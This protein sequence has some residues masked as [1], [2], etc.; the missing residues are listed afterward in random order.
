ML[1]GIPFTSL[2]REVSLR[3]RNELEVANCIIAATLILVA[4]TSG[5]VDPQTNRT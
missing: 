1:S 4:T 2:K 5:L 3:K